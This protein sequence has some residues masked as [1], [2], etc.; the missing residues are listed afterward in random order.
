MSSLLWDRPQ[1]VWEKVEGKLFEGGNI[2]GLDGIRVIRFNVNTVPNG[3]RI[4]KRRFPKEV[5]ISLSSSCPT[6]VKSR[7]A[8]SKPISS[9]V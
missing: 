7:S 5:V 1:E 4:I 2:S 9:Q 8:R 6:Q 3:D